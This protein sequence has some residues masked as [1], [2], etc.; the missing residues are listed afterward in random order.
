MVNAL[1]IY[2]MKMDPRGRIFVNGPMRQY[3]NLK[4]G[5]DS[6]VYAYIGLPDDPSDKALFLLNDD[7]ANDISSRTK[8]EDIANYNVIPKV[9]STN[10]F[11]AIQDQFRPSEIKSNRIQFKKYELKRLDIPKNDNR[12]FIQGAG[13]KYIVWSAPEFKKRYPAEYERFELD[14]DDDE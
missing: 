14:E 7:V 5:E 6:G 1:G 9:A 12:V 3:Y 2:Q 4:K 13:I 8:E 11:K 10:P